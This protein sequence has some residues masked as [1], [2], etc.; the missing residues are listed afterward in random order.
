MINATIDHSAAKIHL[1]SSGMILGLSVFY[2]RT[3]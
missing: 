3:R 1:I 2:D